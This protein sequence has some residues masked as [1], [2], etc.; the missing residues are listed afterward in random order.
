MA[1]R[2][3]RYQQSGDLHFVTFS[4]RVPHASLPLV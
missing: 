2:F 1:K 4:C 3:V